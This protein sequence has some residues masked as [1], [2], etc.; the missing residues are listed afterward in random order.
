MRHSR[1][2][3]AD[4]R[5]GTLEGSEDRM[6]DKS[7]RNRPGI[8][9]A[10]SLEYKVGANRKF[11]KRVKLWAMRV[12]DDAGRKRVENWRPRE[13]GGEIRRPICNFRSSG[14]W[15][16]DFFPNPVLWTL[17]TRK[18][19]FPDVL[20]PRFKRRPTLEGRARSTMKSIRPDEQWKLFS[21]RIARLRWYKGFAAIG[22]RIP[23]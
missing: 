16:V 9:R 1:R 10:S 2:K 11:G 15:S 19:V 18:R 22:K 5:G 8:R 23:C 20:R 17:G 3:F 13:K 14:C 4:S 12:R 7:R 6:R 21:P